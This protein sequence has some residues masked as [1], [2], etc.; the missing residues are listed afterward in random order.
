MIRRAATFTE[1]N[2]GVH[3]APDTPMRRFPVNL[4]EVVKALHAHPHH[5]LPSEQALEAV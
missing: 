5:E 3:L 1:A 2:A 4:T